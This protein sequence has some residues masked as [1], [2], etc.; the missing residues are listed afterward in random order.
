MI[1]LVDNY[2]SFVHNLARYLGE[3]GRE[4]EVLRNDAVTVNELAARRPEAVVL[5]PGPSTPDRAG[6]C[7]EVVRRLGP[8]TPILGV[9]LGHQCVVEAYGG[10]VRRAERPMH[11]RASR[12]EHDGEGLFRGLPRPLVAG[13]YHSLVATLPPS[14]CPLRATAHSADGELMAVQHEELPVY[15]VQFHP[16][17][18]LTEQGHGLLQ[19]FLD[20]VDRWWAAAEDDR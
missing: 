15:G 14:P 13:R 20:E 18:V 11:G 16:E 1:V 19:N 8:R 12:I 4:R 6:V 10:A 9:C 3:L 5:S 17:S 7:V 2:D